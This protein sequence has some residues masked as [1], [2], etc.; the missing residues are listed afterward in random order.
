MQRASKAS[1]RR[2]VAR[3]ANSI[4]DFTCTWG[5]FDAVRRAEVS[6]QAVG[7]PYR[8]LSPDGEL[9]YYMLGICGEVLEPEFQL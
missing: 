6:L 7:F 1:F 9:I 2:F 5:D 4:L 8:N 3:G